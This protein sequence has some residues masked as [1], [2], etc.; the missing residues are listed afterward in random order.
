MPPELPAWSIAPSQAG[1]M[2]QPYG[3]ELPYSVTSSGQSY[4]YTCG[5]AKSIVMGSLTMEWNI[6]DHQYGTPYPCFSH[7]CIDGTGE[8]ADSSI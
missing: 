6:H 7:Y 1:V 4:T 5:P 3:R 2:D 8:E